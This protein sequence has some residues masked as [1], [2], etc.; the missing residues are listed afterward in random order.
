MILK[1]QASDFI[2]TENLPEGYKNNISKVKGGY[3]IYLLDKIELDTMYCIRNI[4]KANNIDQKEINFCGLKD[5]HAKTLQYIS[6]PAKHQIT[7]KEFK[8]FNIKHIGYSD[9][10]LKLGFNKSNSFEITIRKLT[11]IEENDLL[12]N[13]KHIP[14]IRNIFIPNYFDDQRFTNIGLK[15]QLHFDYIFRWD[16][17][18]FLRF[19]LTNIINKDERELRQKKRELEEYFNDSRKNKKRFSFDRKKGS[20]ELQ[21]IYD[22]YKQKKDFFFI[23]KT[24]NKEDIIMWYSAFLSYYFNLALSYHIKDNYSKIKSSQYLLGDLDY[25]YNDKI[26]KKD[27]NKKVPFITNKR[28]PNDFYSKIKFPYSYNNIKIILKKL[29]IKENNSLR[30]LFVKVDNFEYEIKKDELYNEYNK[31]I[32]KFNLPSGAYATNFIKYLFLK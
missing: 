20:F 32:L 1:K 8:L 10:R 12:R 26:E 17:E 21:K 2:V 18:G 22:Q 23:L 24:I 15:K 14:T 29:R 7:K 5:R 6:I 13:I 16:K 4:A 11:G 28:I 3:R 25:I 31:V 9:N 19:F 30:E 27:I